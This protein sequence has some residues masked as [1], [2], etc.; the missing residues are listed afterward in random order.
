MQMYQGKSHLSVKLLD[1]I[2]GS[3]HDIRK[4]GKV[5]QNIT[6]PCAV[7]YVQCSATG[8]ALN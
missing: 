4:Y 5:N 1:Y 2:S 6:L 3:T 8:H 7:V